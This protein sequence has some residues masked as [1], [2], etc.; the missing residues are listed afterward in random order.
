M[1]KLLTLTLLLAS[2]GFMGSFAEVRANTVAKTNPQIRIQIGRDRYRER[3]RWRNNWRNN[4]GE[5][6]YTQ[7]RI[8]RYGF[9]T[10]RETYV[11]RY[12]PWGGTESRLISRERID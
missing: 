9:R 12:T 8:V 3:Y 4:F 2:F 10:Y 1:K 6:E 7:T 11:V 5:R